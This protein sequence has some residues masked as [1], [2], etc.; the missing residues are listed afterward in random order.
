MQL[1]SNHQRLAGCEISHT[2]AGW[3]QEHILIEVV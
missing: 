2:A 3:S 1:N